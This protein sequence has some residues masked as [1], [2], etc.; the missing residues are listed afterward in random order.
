MFVTVGDRVFCR[1]YQYG[2]RSW[3][4]V[5]L[6]DPDGQVWLDGAVVDIE[7]RVPHDLD[8]INPLVND[9]YA[10]ALRR[11]GASFMLAGAIDDRAMA[12]TME[13]TFAS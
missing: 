10:E 13:M 3:R 5:F 2:E 7:G 9:A 4:D 11:L 6:G 8:T 12:S 1:R